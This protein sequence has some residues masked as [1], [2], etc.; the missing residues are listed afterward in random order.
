MATGR[1]RTRNFG[2]VVYPES[3][4]ENWQTIL[5]ELC[6]PCFISPLHDKDINPDGETK[7]TTL[8]CN[9]YV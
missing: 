7:K 5:S 3:A 9:A 8:S 6:I 4:P 2:T 1:G